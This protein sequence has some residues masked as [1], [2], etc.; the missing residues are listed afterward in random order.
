MTTSGNIVGM[1]ASNAVTIGYHLSLIEARL[2]RIEQKLDARAM[3][4]TPEEQ[5][6]YLAALTAD[7][8]KITHA[9]QALDAVTTTLNKT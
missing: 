8:Q 1:D 2:I 5:T 6:A 4:M 3:T 7:V 9:T